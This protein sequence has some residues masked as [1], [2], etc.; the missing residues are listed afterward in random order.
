MATAVAA[1][2]AARGA[3]QRAADEAPA[4]MEAEARLLDQLT[5]IPQITKAT[6][7]PARTGGGVQITVQSAQHNLPVNGKRQL[8][9]TVHVPDA[10]SPGAAF[11][12]G[13]PVELPQ[14]DMQSV[15]PS[16]RR[17]LVVRSNDAGALLEIWDGSRLV[18][19]LQVPKSLHGPV[20][21]DGWF[22]RGAAWSPDEGRICYVAELPA[23]EKTPQWTGADAKDAAAP[24]GWRGVAAA[25]EDWGELNTGKGAPALFA[26]DCGS[27]G[28]HKLRGLPPDHSCGQPVWTP[29]GAGVVFVVW[30]H[31]P[32]NLPSTVRRLGIVFCYNRPCSLLAVPYAA[33]PPP[34]PAGDGEADAAAAAAA[35]SAADDEP[36]AVP[37]S[38]PLLSAFAPVFSPDGRLLVFLSQDAAARSGVHSATASM[39][40]IEWRKDG[41]RDAL[42]SGAPPPRT[43]VPVVRR[44]ASRGGFPGLYAGGFP[45]SPFLSDRTVL[46]NSQWYSQTVGLAVDLVTGEVEPVTPVGWENGSWAVQGVCGGVV[47]AVASRPSRPPQLLLA[48]APPASAAASALSEAAA[49]RPVSALEVSG[50]ALAEGLPDAAA[51]LAGVEAVVLDVTP[52]TGDKTLAFQAVVQAPKS[53]SGPV[54]VIVFP[55][56]GPHTAIGINCYTPFSLFTALGYAVVA[57]NYRGSTGFG[58]DALQ[59]LPGRVGRQDVD[60]CVDALQ[61]AVDAGIADPDRAAVIGGSHGGFL[62]GH[63]VGQFPDRWRCAGLRNPVLN[64]AL[65]VG[66]TDIPDWCYVE[67]MG[68]E[69]GRRRYRPDPTP[70]DLA[71]FA[72][73]SPIAHVAK[74]RAP[75]AF[76]LGAKDRRIPLEDGRRYIDAVRA[77]GVPTRVLCFP[78]DGHA[79]DKPQSDYEQWVNLA[80]WLKRYMWDGEPGAAGTKAS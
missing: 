43:V 14:I 3:P 13:L 12:S 5:S 65:M 67:T 63:L 51:A 46:V 22:S 72:A 2:A 29:D 79:I 47:A 18:K 20:V 70:E 80:W 59:S 15:S 30:P 16:G 4:G 1:P 52:S 11:V 74:V 32:P 61:A 35:A 24:R 62:T 38:A 36:S 66:I 26:L 48:R 10:S 45:E 31:A 53:R 25:Q 9:H 75:L 69:E 6:V 60:D 76:M 40:S 33:P 71:H 50:E 34:P 42:A 37:L 77:A 8:V 73:S 19:E 7:R 55:H 27:W 44:P 68:T 56:G 21:N 49:W 39:H 17:A 64:I 41:S 23:P 58:E 28:V 78:N 57:V 54:P